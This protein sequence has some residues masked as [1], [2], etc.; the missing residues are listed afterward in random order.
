MCAYPIYD[1]SFSLL[2]AT[3]IRLDSHGRGGE[4]VGRTDSTNLHYK[5]LESKYRFCRKLM[6]A[7]CD[8]ESVATVTPWSRKKKA[9]EE[10]K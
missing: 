2:V 7:T 8:Q 9:P 5:K 10:A 4:Y 6:T 1:M 3:C